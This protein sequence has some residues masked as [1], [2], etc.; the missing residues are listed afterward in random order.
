M[1]FMKRQRWDIMGHVLCHDEK[2]HRAKIEDAVEEQK[3]PGRP[4]NS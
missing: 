3:P 2:M 1:N 4:R